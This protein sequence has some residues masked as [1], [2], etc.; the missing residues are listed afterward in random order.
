MGEPERRECRKCD[1]VWGLA[2][3]FFGGLI[4]AIGVDLLTGGALGRVLTG[5]ARKAA[6]AADMGDIADDDAS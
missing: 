6:A 2:G 1:A 3:V 5:G 4:L